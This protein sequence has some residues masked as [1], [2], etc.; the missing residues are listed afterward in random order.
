MHIEL[1]PFAPC[2]G[3][4][5]FYRLAGIWCEPVIFNGLAE[6]PTPSKQPPL[7]WGLFLRWNLPVAF[8]RFWLLADIRLTPE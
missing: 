1:S 8:V 2:F 3:G 6:P 7:R 5:F 4:G